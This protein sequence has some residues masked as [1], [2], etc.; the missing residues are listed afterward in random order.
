VNKNS[1]Q[2]FYQEG[3]AMVEMAIIIG[4]FLAMVF[5][6]TEFSIALLKW[7]RAAEATRAGVRFAIVNTPVCALSGPGAV[8]LL[9][10]AG[11]GAKTV[12]K[13][14]TSTGVDCTDLL[15]EM[16]RKLPDIEA[17]N[18]NITYACSNAGN[19]DNPAFIPAV[20]VE[21]SKLQH[22]LIVPTILGFSAGTTWTVP[23]FAATRLGE[24]LE[25]VTGP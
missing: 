5:A 6:I 13:Q 2:T 18:I 7:G 25:T 10:C 14:C 11:T 17:E 21:L 3:S 24:D 16:Q 12:T 23:N 19:P 8:C 22:T 15:A 20:T 4:L 9:D 1:Q